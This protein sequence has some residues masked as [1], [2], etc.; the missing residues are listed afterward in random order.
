MEITIPPK[1]KY[2]DPYVQFIQTLDS[3]QKEKHLSYGECIDIFKLT[4]TDFVQSYQKY[5]A[6]PKTMKESYEQWQK[7][8]ETSVQI[9]EKIK[10]HRVKKEKIMIHARIDKLEDILKI[11]ETN[12]F[13]DTKEYNINLEG[14][15]KIKDEVKAIHNL[16]GLVSLKKSITRQ[17]L[18]FIQGFADDSSEGDYKHTVLTGPPGSGKTELAK[19]IG[20]MYSK[21]GILKNSKFKKV[22]RADLVAGYLGQTAIKT[23][24]VIDECLGGVLFIDEAYSLH[25]DDMYSKECVDTLCDALS[26][27]KKDLMVI[28]AGYE[29]ELN[30]NF[31]KI[32]AGLSSRFIWRF[33]I[34]PYLADE[35]YLI[36]KYMV[37]KGG[38]EMETDNTKWFVE[39]KDKFKD[40]GRSME[41]L[42]LCTKICHAKRIF[43]LV[44]DDIVKVKCLTL[45][46]LNDGFIFYDENAKKTKDMLYGLYI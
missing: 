17:L 38:W 21:M 35:L 29:N 39:K 27:N 43:G 8:H 28:V 30:E 4:Q 13:D 10:V 3:F 24:K 9:Q 37:E 15:H 36:F 31:F 23:T 42:F 45:Q 2:I 19:L 1:E 44:T 12:S 33:N 32:N 26:E 34:A 18:Y 7:E 5:H 22:T 6:D 41:H 20:K 16:V 14:L 46:D 25:A 11:I 40:N